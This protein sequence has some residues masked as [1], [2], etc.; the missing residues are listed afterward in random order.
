MGGC[1]MVCFI[2][3]IIRFTIA[4]KYRMAHDALHHGSHVRHHPM[5]TQKHAFLGSN[6]SGAFGAMQHGPLNAFT[7]MSLPPFI[8]HYRGS[9]LRLNI[10]QGSEPDCVVYFSNSRFTHP[11]NYRLLCSESSQGTSIVAVCA[12]GLRG[13]TISRTC[14]SPPCF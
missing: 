4:D 6:L 9:N 13:F 7:M 14:T 2:N 10:E 3:P 1:Y 5:S 12:G 8:C 11:D